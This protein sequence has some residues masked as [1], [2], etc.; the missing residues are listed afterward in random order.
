MN[1]AIDV[2]QLPAG[3]YAEGA[4]ASRISKLFMSGILIANLAIAGAYAGPLDDHATR[5]ATV[6]LA[7]E[8]RTL[9]GV[10]PW[11]IDT[12][13]SG[14]V[15]DAASGNTCTDLQYPE[16]AGDIGVVLGAM[17]L[18]DALHASSTPRIIFG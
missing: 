12:M 13:L 10:A 18:D 14:A 11:S 1:H 3:D 2:V 7:T 16:L 17:S 15:C 6:S 5:R 9:K 8:V 4:R